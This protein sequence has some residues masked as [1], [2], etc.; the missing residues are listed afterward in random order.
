MSTAFWEKHV[1]RTNKQKVPD[2]HPAT[3]LSAQETLEDFF[4][5]NS[6]KRQDVQTIIKEGY[7]ILRCEERLKFMATVS[8]FELLHTYNTMHSDFL[9]GFQMKKKKVTSATI[10]FKSYQ[11]CTEQPKQAIIF[12][13]SP[14]HNTQT[15]PN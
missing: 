4:S 1:L 14:T 5:P 10:T 9:A 3:V 2:T 8:Y 6:S 13:F 15:I 11:R 12:L 7:M